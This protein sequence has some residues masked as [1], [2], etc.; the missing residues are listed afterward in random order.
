VA[1][2][3]VSE[4]FLGIAWEADRGAAVCNSNYLF[5]FFVLIE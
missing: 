1:G 2:V 5:D 3:A 4:S